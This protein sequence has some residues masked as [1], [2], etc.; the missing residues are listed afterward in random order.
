MGMNNLKHLRDWFVFLHPKGNSNWCFGG[1]STI[2]AGCAGGR[3]QIWVH[4][5]P[6]QLIW[7]SFFKP[8]RL[9]QRA[10]KGFECRV[11]GQALKV[12]LL[13]SYTVSTALPGL[14]DKTQTIVSCCP[15]KEQTTN[16]MG[17]CCHSCN[18]DS[19]WKSKAFLWFANSGRGCDKMEEMCYRPKQL[20]VVD[21]I[22]HAF[23]YW[24]LSVSKIRHRY[25]VTCSKLHP[26]Q[27]N[28]HSL[29]QHLLGFWLRNGVQSWSRAYF[30]HCS[31]KKKSV[32]KYLMMNVW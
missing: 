5:M 23:N 6:L 27:S 21:S 25:H 19:V 8:Q 32:I 26:M 29:I 16:F 3:V 18:T 12:A 4:V 13:L 28:W 30:C 10:I 7:Q 14:T 17:K 11:N 1:D 24:S 2:T 22:V 9:F 15:C 31:T 20:T